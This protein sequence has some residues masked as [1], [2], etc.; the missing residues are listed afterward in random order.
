MAA[1]LAGSPSNDTALDLAPVLAALRPQLTA[2]AATE[3]LLARWR[4]GSPA[5]T[6]LLA[7]ILLNA[8]SHFSEFRVLLHPS[9]AYHTPSE[10]GFS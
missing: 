5:S 9:F 1:L 10:T 3:L 8:S 4:T 2:A 7:S 6:A